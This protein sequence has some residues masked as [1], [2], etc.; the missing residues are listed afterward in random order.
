[1]HYFYRKFF[2]AFRGLFIALRSDLGFQLQS[3]FFVISGAGLFLFFRPFTLYELLFIGL[4]YSLLFIT[5]LQNTAF[6]K[7]LDTLH[8]D[9]HTHI[10]HSKDIAAGAVLIALIYFV[11]VVG[12]LLFARTVV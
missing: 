9:T 12:V 3:I 6:E 8:P 1:M 5:E 4:A 10:G 2:H 11:I 7:A